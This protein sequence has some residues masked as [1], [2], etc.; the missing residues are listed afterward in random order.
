MTKTKKNKR[1]KTK[2]HGKAENTESPGMENHCTR[3][4]FIGGGSI[5]ASSMNAVS[6]SSL[7]TSPDLKN[8]TCLC[9]RHWKWCK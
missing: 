6:S 2:K 5:L 9:K 1:Q 7:L 8:D 3:L 4:L